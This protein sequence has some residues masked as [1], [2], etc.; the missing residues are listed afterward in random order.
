MSTPLSPSETAFLASKIYSFRTDELLEA[1]LERSGG[2]IGIG[3]FELNPRNRLEGRSGI[4]FI[5]TRS[6]FGCIAKGQ[7]ARKNEVLLVTRGTVTEYDWLSNVNVGYQPGPSGTPVHA[8]FNNIFQSFRKDLEAFFRGINPTHVH[9][10]GHSLGGA[11]ATLAAD[12]IRSRRIA[13]VSLYTYGSPRVGLMP[14]SE[15]LSVDVGKNIYRVFHTADP[16]SMV[17]LFPFQH[18]STHHLPAQLIWNGGFVSIDAHSME[19]YTRSVGQSGWSGL[20]KPPPS[21]DWRAQIESWLSTAK[22]GPGF[23]SA[24]L[25]GLISVA[26]VKIVAKVIAI[27]FQGILSVGLTALDAL[28]QILYRGAMAVKEIAEDLGWVLRAILRFL[29]RIVALPGEL[30]AAFIRWVLESLYSTLAAI[31]R[32]AL[33]STR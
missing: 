32:R 27:G 14:F 11:L 24:R 15:Q 3:T 23:L 18:V 9:C 8:G 21:I 31:A 12:H 17:P 26:L 22:W 4:A 7:G 25:L 19:N 5:N 29:G 2:S 16:V 30:T 6:A 1:E 10:V 28:S 33:E 13:G 20:I